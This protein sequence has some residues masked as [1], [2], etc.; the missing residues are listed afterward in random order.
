MV[1]YFSYLINF[2]IEFPF[3]NLFEISK[4]NNVGKFFHNILSC[5]VTENMDYFSEEQFEEV[6][7]FITDNPEIR[8]MNLPIAVINYD[9]LHRRTYSIES[10]FFAIS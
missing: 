9:R 8:V 1:N 10:H 7:S 6:Y 4:K 5:V 2:R 3:N